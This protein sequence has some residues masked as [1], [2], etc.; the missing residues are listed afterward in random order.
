MSTTS[1]SIQV[2]HQIWT[3]PIPLV[4]SSFCFIG[5]YVKPGS[6]HRLYNDVFCPDFQGIHIDLFCKCSVAFEILCES[7]VALSLKIYQSTGATQK[8]GYST[9]AWPGGLSYEILLDCMNCYSLERRRV[10]GN[11]IQLY[12]LVNHLHNAAVE[13]FSKPTPAGKLERSSMD[14]IQSLVRTSLRALSFLVRSI[15]LWNALP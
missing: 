2:L 4:G 1:N 10:C 5:T 13:S 6:N 12:K 9:S 3:S 11:S 8:S 15:K 14:V 7:L